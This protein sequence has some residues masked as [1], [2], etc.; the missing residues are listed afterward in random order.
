MLSVT[1]RTVQ[2][3]DQRSLVSP[4][5]VTEGGR[6]MYSDDDVRRLRAVCYLREVGLPIASIQKLVTE[7][8]P[9]NVIS[10][11]IG[12]QKKE[13]EDEIDRVV[14]SV[15]QESVG[16]AVEH[17]T[18][19]NRTYKLR[20]S[21]KYKVEPDGLLLYNDAEYASNV[22]QKGYDVLSGAALFAEKI[23]GDYYNVMGLPVCRLVQVLRETVPELMEEKR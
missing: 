10:L 19:Q 2:Y 13:L 22:E 7:E 18:Y 17:G 8:H 4:S 12:Q 21:N 15:G 5:G 16:Y 14:D 6:R 23:H 1:V 11:M 9:E 3:Y 20:S